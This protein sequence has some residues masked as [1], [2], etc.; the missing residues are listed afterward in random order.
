[1]TEYETM[2]TS[3]TIKP[4]GKALYSDEATRISI[5]DTGGGLFVTVSQGH[6]EIGIN[7]DEWTMLKDAI[8]RM[9]AVC[10]DH[11]RE[12]VGKWN[13]KGGGS[14]S[15]SKDDG[16]KFVGRSDAVANRQRPD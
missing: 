9:M 6:H 3:I 5:D 12:V 10:D 14:V 7:P 2:M 4:K 11:Q 8:E 16:D 15:F 13:L 1:M